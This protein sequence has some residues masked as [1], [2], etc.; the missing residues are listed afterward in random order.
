MNEAAKFE[1]YET[2]LKGI[3]E[4]NKLMYL[5]NPYEYP[6]TLTIR[7][8]G[9]S[10]AQLSFAPEATK[11]ETS[12]DAY[13]RIS[14]VD[15]DVDY[16]FSDT[17][18]IG[19]ALLAKIKRLA[20]NMYECWTQFLHREV[21]TKHLLEERVITSMLESAKEDA[22]PEDAEPMEEF[23]E[24]YDSAEVMGADE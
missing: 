19:D 6:V 15:G 21:M 20:K 23:E 2:K 11:E 4:E 14:F 7:P 5:F 3:C 1:V 10:N 24:E 22:L 17:F 16:K 12:P 8:T 18:I 13:L 9:E